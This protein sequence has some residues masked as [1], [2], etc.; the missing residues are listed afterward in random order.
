MAVIKTIKSR[1]SKLIELRSRHRLV[2]G[3]EEGC[4]VVIDHDKAVSRK[5][6][7]I[8]YDRVNDDYIIKDMGSANGTFVNG[9][10]IFGNTLLKY[11]DEIH[12]GFFQYYRFESGQEDES[13][14]RHETID[15]NAPN[16][17]PADGES[18]GDVGHFRL[19][20][21]LGEG[22][23]S[24]VYLAEDITLSRKVALKFMN[25]RNIQQ[26]GSSRLREFHEQS[27]ISEAK[28]A[29]LINHANIAH[30]HEA[31]FDDDRWYIAMEY[32]DGYSLATL[33][34]HGKPLSIGQIINIAYQT[35]SGLKH[36][37]DVY[38]IIHRDIKPQNIMITT[39]N[40]VKIV[41]MGLATPVSNIDPEKTLAVDGPVGTPYYMA[42]EQ[43]IGKNDVDHRADIFALGSTLYELSTGQKPF[44]ASNAVS[45]FKA[46]MNRNYVRIPTLRADFPPALADIID[47][48]LAPA[49][50]HRLD[51]YADLIKALWKIGDSGADKTVEIEFP[52]LP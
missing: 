14:V 34:E 12:V 10:P 13:R 29:A 8:E 3:R 2:F 36:A 31:N 41:D 20:A 19:L 33:L 6:C 4:D 26:H 16:S 43:T 1:S 51:S 42:P 52:Q 49:P 30:I 27:F 21:K 5:H 44:N 38:K 25:W 28:T 39:Y 7:C 46:K 40:S 35:A 11:G 15:D 48:M 47:Q 50:E 17:V 23:M 9:N 45:I 32:I 22:G 18:L 37:W 24:A